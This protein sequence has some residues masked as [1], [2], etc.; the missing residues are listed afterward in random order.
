MKKKLGAI[1][2]SLKGR[3]PPFRFCP[4]LLYSAPNPG[5]PWGAFSIPLPSVFHLSHSPLF[6][7]PLCLSFEL[8]PLNLQLW[9]A[10]GM[11]DTFSRKFARRILK[12]RGKQDQYL[13]SQEEGTR[14]SCP[15]YLAVLWLAARSFCVL[16]FRASFLLAVTSWRH[17]WEDNTLHRKG[18]RDIVS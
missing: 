6:L 17:T 1:F 18:R 3:R 2:T 9:G 16:S 4:L 7:I 11:R 12:P 5:G 8:Y 10:A 15:W 13:V 14:W